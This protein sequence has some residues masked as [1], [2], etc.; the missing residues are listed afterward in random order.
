M[1]FLVS[2]TALTCVLPVP[3]P[4]CGAL[5]FP[6]A[7]G[8]FRSAMLT[9]LLLVSA[10]ISQANGAASPGVA[11]VA[12]A[13]TARVELV[14]R[15]SQ[16]VVAV[17]G[18]TGGGGGS[19]VVISPDG[20]A[21]SNYHVTSACGTFMK[22]GLPNGELYDAVI[23]GIDPTGDVALL[24]LVG[25]DDFPTATLGDS[26]ALE[27]GDWVF[28][29]GNPF[30]LATDFTPT[31]TYGIVSGTHRYQYPA[32]TFLEY[33]DC[34]QIDAS[35]NPGNSGGPLFN[36]AGELVGINGRG[37]F[38]KRGRVNSGAAYAISIN[39]IKHFLDHLHSGRIVDHATLGAVVSTRD[40]GAVVVDQILEES[41]AWRR[42]LREGDEIVAF[43]G[44]PIT[45]AN[46]F[47]NLLGIYPT[48]HRLPLAFRRD[49]STQEIF[50]RLRP[51][52]SEAELL[53]FVEGPKR[54]PGPEKPRDGDGKP[55]PK[56]GE[57]KPG[58]PLPP[59]PGHGDADE[60][61]KPPE[62]VAKL[63]EKR[64]GYTNYYFNRLHQ[65]RV[66]RVLTGWGDFGSA[67][68][69]W[70]LTGTW[71]PRGAEVAS[72]CLL[73]LKSAGVALEVASTPPELY[74]QFLDESSRLVDEPKGTG[75]LLV[76]LDQ[77]KR[78]L[79]ARANGF[80]ELFYLGSEPLDGTGEPVDVVVTRWRGVETHWYFTK[81]NPRLIG[82]NSTLGPDVDP[83]E[84][85]ILEGAPVALG[86]AKLPGR[87]L[88][89]SGTAPFAVLTLKTGVV[90]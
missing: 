43:A 38:E 23:V 52:H 17:F 66:L 9:S 62:A 50:A 15:V 58:Q 88:I 65:E 74:G 76:A 84:I 61:P 27:V 22:C 72:N 46:Q 20:F 12:D 81:A 28:A 47:K 54:T 13:E 6:F 11:A 30:L 71:Q 24:K 8:T 85:R 29:M 83:C 87:M 36:S 4:G 45:G 18:P 19:G 49:A 77:F 16:S 35:I 53:R 59:A 31:V 63:F 10:V 69:T 78:L 57:E 60:G 67:G 14:A 37:S 68:K 42:G 55:A 25:R 32:G 48:G 79:A 5:S 86:Q 64:T 34:I 41:E 39:Q 21:L 26:D 51:L 73:S 82:W 44:R 75:G 1:D 90:E 70:K 3:V 80:D 89:S 2:R 56:P 33:T 7:V 40:D